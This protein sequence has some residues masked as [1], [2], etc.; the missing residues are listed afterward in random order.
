MSV[1]G[2]QEAQA[3]TTETETPEATLL[4]TLDA[5]WDETAE[6]E[7]EAESPETPAAEQEAA[8]AAP[9][10]EAEEAEAA[11]AEDADDEPAGPVEA[12]EHWPQADKDL[13]DQ[14]PD[15]SKSWFLDK[16]KSLEAGYD[17]KFKEVADQRKRFSAYEQIDQLIEPNRE[18]LR[19]AGVTE[20]AYIGQLMAADR[21]LRE[22]PGEAIAWLAQTY[23]IDLKQQTAGQES[24][25]DMLDPVAA[26]RIDTLTSKI[27]SL[28]TQLQ[29]RQQ[30][31]QQ[32]GANALQGRIDEFRDAA[33]EKGNP[34]HPHFEEV[35]AHMGALIN[36]GA[37]TDLDS[38]Y[39]QAIWASPKLRDDLIARQTTEAA[40]TAQAAR[41]EQVG[42]AKKASRNVNGTGAAGTVERE[43][44][45]T[46]LE[47]LERQWD[48]LAPT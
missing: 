45:D 37:A 46:H 40:K 47:E 31:E 13:F 36:S 2:G 21:Y 15:D 18:Q 16:T 30:A 43:E 3:E 33:D 8:E 4:D 12:P 23:G 20:Q 9:E 19:L 17:S 42:K 44:A 24:E 14:L 1:D 41:Q 34:A 27:S 10:Q 11:A 29:Q 48:E 5:A 38:A 35:R 28:E 26:T 22:K 7:A 6:A 25:A 39:E 32:A